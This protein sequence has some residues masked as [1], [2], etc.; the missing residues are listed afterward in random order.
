MSNFHT[1]QL[2]F[3]ITGEVISSKP[4]APDLDPSDGTIRCLQLLLVN[5]RSVQNETVSIYSI[6]VDEY[7]NLACVAKTKLSNDG[8]QY[9]QKYSQL[10]FSSCSNCNTLVW[11]KGQYRDFLNA[12]PKRK[13]RWLATNA[14]FI[15][16]NTYKCGIGPQR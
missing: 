7:I 11:Q 1:F 8:I 9:Y 16:T 10:R 2:H 4:V 5:A 15:C 12:V 13:R 6:V 14:T 3:A